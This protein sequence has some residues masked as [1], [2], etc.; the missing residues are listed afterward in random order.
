LFLNLFGVFLVYSHIGALE[1]KLVK[2]W[3][4]EP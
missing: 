2:N 4:F 3:I 1:W